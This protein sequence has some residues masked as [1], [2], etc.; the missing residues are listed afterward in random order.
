MQ[1]P[2]SPPKRSALPLKACS[3]APSLSISAREVAHDADRTV[4]HGAEDVVDTQGVISEI[5]EHR[6]DT[7]VS[8][9]QLDTS[10]HTMNASPISLAVSADP[11]PTRPLVILR[12]RMKRNL[13]TSAICPTP[14][15]WPKR[16]RSNPA[17]GAWA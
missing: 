14:S 15:A 8:N 11:E 3:P 2:A 13:P 1:N 7:E 9:P 17:T 10:D 5:A 4:E 6:V 12:P 16:A